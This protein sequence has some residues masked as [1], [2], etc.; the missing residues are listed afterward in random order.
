MKLF[1]KNKIN[2]NIYINYMNKKLILVIIII[3]LLLSK[4]NSKEKF[5][6][7]RIAKTS[8]EI[9]KGLMYIKEPLP[10]NEGMI[11]FLPYRNKHS[12]WMKNTYIPLD[13]IFIDKTEKKNNFKIIGF[14][15]NRK[16]LEEISMG[17]KTPSDYV[18]EMNGGWLDKNKIKKGDIIEINY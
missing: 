4:N 9:Q 6:N 18:L 12:F 15:K 1:I 7:A 17:I 13:I 14:N 3:I 10:E 11:F 2:I 8:Q 16:P 5:I